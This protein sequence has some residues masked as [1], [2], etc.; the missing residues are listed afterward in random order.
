[1][2]DSNWTVL[3][4]YTCECSLKKDECLT[5]LHTLVYCLNKH[6]QVWTFLPI[7][8]PFVQRSLTGQ[9]CERLTKK[10]LCLQQQFAYICMRPVFPV[11]RY[12][13]NIESCEVTGTGTT[14]VRHPRHLSIKWICIDRL[15][16]T[17][18]QLINIVCIRRK[19]WSFSPK[20]VVI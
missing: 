20:N 12:L 8:L 17:K 18:W 1:M 19:F 6:T 16:I 15:W 9:T 11:N 2:G 14:L 13:F 5:L 3:N 7:P 10:A 4:K